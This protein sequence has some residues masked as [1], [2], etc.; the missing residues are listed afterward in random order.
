MAF[1]ER[2]RSQLKVERAG[3]APVREGKRASAAVFM[4]ES[5]VEPER[6]FM[7][8]CSAETASSA[9]TGLERKVPTFYM[10]S[11]CSAQVEIPP[12]TLVCVPQCESVHP[13]LRL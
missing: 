9:Q 11:A 7:A 13:G 12:K 4:E 1:R 3:L 5:K 6:L 10:R 8:E 2:E